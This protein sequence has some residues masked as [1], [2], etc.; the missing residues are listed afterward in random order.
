[1]EKPSQ[2]RIREA[3]AEELVAVEICCSE[4]SR[5]IPDFEERFLRQE[6]LV[7]VAEQ[8]GLIVGGVVGSK[9]PQHTQNLLPAFRMEF[10]YVSR[11]FRNQG[12]ARALFEHLFRLLVSRK[13]GVI[14]ISLFQS[15]RRG[16]RFLEHMGFSRRRV[17]RGR[18]EF[19][20]SLW[21]SYGVVEEQIEDEGWYW[22]P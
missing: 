13:F 9:D 16:I 19:E 20:K 21:E 10:L 18:I 12:I 6:Y 4:L 8:R 5:L 11:A 17:H 2:L 15:Y 22:G 1:M 7:L 14:L 3:R